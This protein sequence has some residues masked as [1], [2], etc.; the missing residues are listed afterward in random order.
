MI[1]AIHDMYI[2]HF[3]HSHQL[4]ICF[5]LITH[6]L[7]VYM[8]HVQIKQCKNYLKLHHWKLQQ[9]TIMG[10]YSEK[11]FLAYFSLRSSNSIIKLDCNVIICNSRLVYTWMMYYTLLKGR[12]DTIIDLWKSFTAFYRWPEWKIVFSFQCL[13]FNS[14]IRNFPVTNTKWR[15]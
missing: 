8:G 2:I 1:Y 6:L 13:P 11:H 9:H 12:F 7:G 14:N 4:P 15:T 3:K 5:H 10:K